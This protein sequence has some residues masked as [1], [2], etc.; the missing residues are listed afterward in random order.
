M[1]FRIMSAIAA[2]LFAAAVQAADIASPGVLVKTASQDVIALLKKTH[3][4][5]HQPRAAILEKIAPDFDFTHMTRLAVGQYW[6]QATPQQ[7]AALTRQFRDLLVNTY[8]NA[9]SHY[10]NQTV[11]YEPLALSPNAS[12]ATVQMIFVERG[13]QRVPINYYM[14]KMV[15]GWKVYDVGVDG[16]SL[17]IN[18]RNSFADEIQRSGINGLISVL[19]RKNASLSGDRHSGGA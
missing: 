10:R 9:M 13:G 3:G 19:A 5:A 4:G 7:Q 6:R 1:A 16:V 8:A 14:Q 11:Q 18:Y 15:D 12:Y 17:V 2:C